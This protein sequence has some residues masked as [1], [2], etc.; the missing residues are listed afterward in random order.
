MQ[1][2]SRVTVCLEDSERDVLQQMSE[3]DRRPPRDQIRHLV[4]E[5]ASRRG[6]IK[7]EQKNQAVSG[8]QKS[9]RNDPTKDP[10]QV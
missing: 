8:E 6:L 3:M 10:L 2:V 5:E 1:M 4:W 7:S 9:T